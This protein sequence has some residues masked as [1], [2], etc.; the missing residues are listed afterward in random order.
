[1]KPPRVAPAPRSGQSSPARPD[2][3]GRRRSSNR[4]L[5]HRRAELASFWD[6]MC[7]GGG[8][9]RGCLGLCAVVMT[10]MLTAGVGAAG[11][12]EPTFTARGSV[13]QVYVTGAAAGDQLSLL[14]S[15]GAV[16]ATRDVN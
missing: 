16:V 12:A 6:G 8:S 13:E 9:W 2:Y 7:S 15:A 4:E 3:K 1:M 14:D 10:V 11:A 5:R